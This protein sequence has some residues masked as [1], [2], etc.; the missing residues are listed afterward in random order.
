M[1]PQRRD[2]RNDAPPKHSFER[3]ANGRTTE[4]VT[5][6]SCGHDWVTPDVDP[7]EDEDGET[8]YLNLCC[9]CRA[10]CRRTATGELME[11]DNS[12]GLT[13]GERG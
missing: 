7:V 10:W 6:V 8:L 5:N 3:A 11:Y 12:D 13:L 9:K 2:T 1:Q 4:F